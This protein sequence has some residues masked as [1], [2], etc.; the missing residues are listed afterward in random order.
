MSHFW[1][2]IRQITWKH[3]QTGDFKG[4]SIISKDISEELPENPEKQGKG[5][6]R[7]LEAGARLRRAGGADLMMKVCTTGSVRAAKTPALNGQRNRKQNSTQN[8][9]SLKT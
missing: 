7:R 5:E 3:A 6:S 9:K 4:V 2:R 1:H 8:S